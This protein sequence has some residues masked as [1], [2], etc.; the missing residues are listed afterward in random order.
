M[1]DGHG[2]EG[3]GGT[4][5]SDV[6]R[7]ELGRLI[8]GGADIVKL[9]A[10]AA[11]ALLPTVLPQS[12]VPRQLAPILAAGSMLTLLGFLVAAAFRETVW[13]WRK[14]I[15]ILAV[16]GGLGAVTLRVA[17]VVP[18]SAGNPP[19]TQEFLVGFRL[20]PDGKRMVEAAGQAQASRQT[21]VAAVGYDQIPKMYGA[22]YATS[23]ALYTLCLYVLLLGTVVGVT[24]FR[25]PLRETGGGGDPGT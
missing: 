24:A 17:L 21:Q 23:F 9:G 10:A 18:V 5:A 7:S 15:V 19:V 11:S 8:E 14:G 3:R 6:R 16:L 2:G 1:D 12:I 25:A 4:V 13:A 22:S 20:S